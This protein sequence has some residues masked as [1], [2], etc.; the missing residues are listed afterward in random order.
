MEVGKTGWRSG[1]EYVRDKDGKE[2][3]KKLFF[4]Q[5]DA[6]KEL[7]KELQEN[8]IWSEL[9][10]DKGYRV[11]RPDTKVDGPLEGKFLRV[12]HTSST[13]PDFIKLL[14]KKY[15]KNLP[16]GL[17]DEFVN[18]LDPKLWRI[19]EMTGNRFLDLNSLPISS[20]KKEEIRNYFE[21]IGPRM[22]GGKALDECL[23]RY[24]NGKIVVPRKN[25]EDLRTLWRL[26]AEQQKH[27]SLKKA[28]EKQGKSLPVRV[29]DLDAKVKEER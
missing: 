13:Y 25:T 18:H 16:E 19:D 14:Q 2:T 12:I 1:S 24:V 28:L 27:F 8:G 21:P 20:L 9:V 4:L 5:A 17:F 23:G 15:G 10:S 7:L 29:L 6:N 3:D 26:S 11:I 22:K